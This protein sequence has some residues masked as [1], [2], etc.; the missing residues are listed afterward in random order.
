[1]SV[2]SYNS[3]IGE[4]LYS[5]QFETNEFDE[6]KKIEDEIRK[7]IDK[8]VTV[9][10]LKESKENDKQDYIHYNPEYRYD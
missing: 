5:I 4:G 2:I 8:R 9:R 1:M 3:Q 7:L 10:L 6:F